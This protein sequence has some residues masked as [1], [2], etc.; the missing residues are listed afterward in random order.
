MIQV[1]IE[2]T[3]KGEHLKATYETSDESQVNAYVEIGEEEI[4]QHI[5][6]YLLDLCIGHV[7]YDK[8]RE[9]EITKFEK[10]KKITIK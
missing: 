3:F 10:K 6:E 7:K 9:K 1:T 4:E 5:T 8:M 2:Y